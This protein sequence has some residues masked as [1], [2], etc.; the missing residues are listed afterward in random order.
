MRRRRYLQV[1][2][3]TLAGGLAGCNDAGQA[4]TPESTGTPTDTPTETPTPTEEEQEPTPTD[5]DQDDP[6]TD[7]PNI[8]P[9]LWMKLLPR[10]NFT[11]ESGDSTAFARTDWKWYLRMKDTSPD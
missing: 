1:A 11:N 10:K 4:D 2:G 5:D 8:D 9:P 3:L 7:A 6:E